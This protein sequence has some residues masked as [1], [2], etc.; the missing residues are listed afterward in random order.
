MKNKLD[1]LSEK[2]EDLE[3]RLKQVEDKSSVIYVLPYVMPVVIKEVT[4]QP[5]IPWPT[6][7]GTTCLS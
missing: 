7:R 5:E 2:I 4:V 1:E 3:Q 6:W